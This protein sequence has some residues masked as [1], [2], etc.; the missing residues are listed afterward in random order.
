MPQAFFSK[1]L[2]NRFISRKREYQ[3]CEL[4]TSLDDIKGIT[5]EIPN[6]TT[7]CKTVTCTGKSY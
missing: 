3:V 4:C 5:D 2:F 1:Y 7:D 6:D